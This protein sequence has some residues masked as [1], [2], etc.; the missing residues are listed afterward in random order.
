LFSELVRVEILFNSSIASFFL[1]MIFICL[2][3]QIDR[4]AQNPI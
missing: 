3:F 2:I 4:K 1:F